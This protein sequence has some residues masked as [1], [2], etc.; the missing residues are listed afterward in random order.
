MDE[1][2]QANQVDRKK[3]PVLLGADLKMDPKSERFTNSSKAN[4]MLIRDYRKP[5]VVPEKV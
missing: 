1:H 4:K 2:L 3:Y 5:F